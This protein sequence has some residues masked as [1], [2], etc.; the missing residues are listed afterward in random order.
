MKLLN[1]SNDTNYYLRVIK[2]TRTRER[3]MDDIRKKKQDSCTIKNQ[4]K[5]NIYMNL[6][7]YMRCT[8]KKATCNKQ[9][10]TQR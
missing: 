5:I 8:K 2:S 1:N 7:I 6:G 4:N 9:R 3:D 10:A